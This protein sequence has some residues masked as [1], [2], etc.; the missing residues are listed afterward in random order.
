[1][2]D[3]TTTHMSLELV[4][5]FDTIS[6]HIKYKLDD[7]KTRALLAGF[8]A[9]PMSI[10]TIIATP[11]PLLM[12]F[13]GLFA[14]IFLL[15]T[16][17]YALLMSLVMISFIILHILGVVG[18]WI[19]LIYTHDRFTRKLRKIT[20]MFL[21][22]GIIGSFG[23][24]GHSFIPTLVFTL[25]ALVGVAFIIGTPFVRFEKLKHTKSIDN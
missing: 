23:F 19:R 11:V 5:K 3:N 4:E 7:T 20:L 1:M 21:N 8:I 2:E 24:V 10:F 12:G 15:K 22:F 14:A 25:M 9:L 17:I 16:E 13:K 18:I 6:E